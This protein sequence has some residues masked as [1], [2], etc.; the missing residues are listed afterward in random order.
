MA[1]TV[2]A[3]IQDPIQLAL[4]SGREKT[5][6]DASPLNRVKLVLLDRT[7]LATL[8]TLD[9]SV[10]LNIFYWNRTVQTV[11]GVPAIYLLELEL[12]DSGLPV[13][14]NLLARL[15]LYDGDNPLGISWK[16]F[17]LNSR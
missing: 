6:V 1:V 14:E 9:S 8:L 13:Q 3:G 2:T 11:K 10:D 5:P 16:Q 15:T 17:S 4:T 12:H 7:T